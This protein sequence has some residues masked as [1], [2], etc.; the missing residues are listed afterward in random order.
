MNT[1]WKKSK[2]TNNLVKGGVQKFLSQTRVCGKQKS[3]KYSLQKSQSNGKLNFEG[4]Q[5]SPWWLLTKTH[6]VWNCPTIRGLFCLLNPNW[7]EGEYFYLVFIFGSD[8]V[9]WIFIEN[10]QSYSGLSLVHLVRY[11]LQASVDMDVQSVRRLIDDWR[12]ARLM[13][14]CESADFS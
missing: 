3:T 2:S 1:A 8:F 11:V 5:K 13:R 12:E 10:F 9:S 4:P 7:H 6:F 14:L